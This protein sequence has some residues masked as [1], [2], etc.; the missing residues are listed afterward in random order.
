MIAALIGAGGQ[1]LFWI[2]RALVPALWEIREKS[3][4]AVEADDCSA[5][6]GESL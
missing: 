3:H 2:V 1:I 6:R 4:E 5:L